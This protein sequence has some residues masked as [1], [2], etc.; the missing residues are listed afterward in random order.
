MSLE[1]KALR[2]EVP[3]LS[4]RLG[5]GDTLRLVLEYYLNESNLQRNIFGVRSAF[6]KRSKSATDGAKRVRCNHDEDAKN[7]ASFPAP[8]APTTHVEKLRQAANASGKAAKQ[9]QSQRPADKPEIKSVGAAATETRE[10][11]PD[12]SALVPVRSPGTGV[13]GP[14]RTNEGEDDHDGRYAVEGK[15]GISGE[16]SVVLGSGSQSQRQSHDVQRE[17]LASS[18]RRRVRPADVATSLLLE[19]AEK[20]ADHDIGPILKF[21]AESRAGAVLLAGATIS[22]EPEPVA[23]DGSN[24]ASKIAISGGDGT[25]SSSVL[26]LAST[27]TSSNAPPGEVETTRSKEESRSSC[28]LKP[29]PKVEGGAAAGASL[30]LDKETAA[31]STVSKH[32]G[33]KAGD[34]NEELH[35]RRSTRK[36]ARRCR[37]HNGKRR[38][39]LFDVGSEN[40]DEAGAS[41]GAPDLLN[42]AF[43]FSIYSQHKVGQLQLT[44]AAGTTREG[45][46]RATTIQ[47]EPPVAA[48]YRTSTN[49]G[50]RRTTNNRRGAVTT[51]GLNMAKISSLGG[52]EVGDVESRSRNEPQRPLS[53]RVVVAE[54]I[55][56]T[57][58]GL[59]LIAVLQLEPV[60]RLGVYLPQQVA[61]ALRRSESLFVHQG[62]LFRFHPVEPEPARGAKTSTTTTTSSTG[63]RTLYV[64]NA[65]V[66]LS[67][68]ALLV[69]FAYLVRQ[70][71]Q[72]TEGKDFSR[73]SLGGE[74]DG[75]CVDNDDVDLVL[76]AET[77]ARRAQQANSTR[78][79][80][81]PEVHL[82]QQIVD[83]DHRRNNCSTGPTRGSSRDHLPKKFFARKMQGE[84][85]RISGDSYPAARDLPQHIRMSP[86]PRTNRPAAHV[87]LEF[88]SLET[89]LLA[90]A[91]LHNRWPASWPERRDGKVLRVLHQ[92]ELNE[93]RKEYK[94][95]GAINHATSS[96]SSRSR[97]TTTTG[98]SGLRGPTSQMPDSAASEIVLVRLTLRC[99]PTHGDE[100]EDQALTPFAVRQY[101]EHAVPVQHVHMQGVGKKVKQRTELL[102]PSKSKTSIIS[103]TSRPLFSMAS[104][105]PAADIHF[106]QDAVVR[107]SSA[108]DVSLLVRDIERS[109]RFLGSAVPQVG[110]FTAM[111][112]LNYFN[113]V[114]VKLSETRK[115]QARMVLP[116][117]LKRAGAKGGAPS[118]FSSSLGLQLSSPASGTLYQQP[119]LMSK[120]GTG[121]EA[122]PPEEKKLEQEVDVLVSSRA[123]GEADGD[124]DF[125]AEVVQKK[126]R[127]G[128]LRRKH[129]QDRLR[130]PLFCG[131]ANP[132]RIV[133]GGPVRAV[134]H[135][136][137]VAPAQAGVGAFRWQRDPRSAGFTDIGPPPKCHD[138]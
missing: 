41:E 133:R 75:S 70:E 53:S 107:L 137:L 122:P 123:E 82:A 60:R 86:H 80:E 26:K 43:G 2:V 87:F 67:L 88:E 30:H 46:D 91:A 51:S 52:E 120:T 116:N 136:A 112:Q 15:A 113:D 81:T 64:E 48:N 100:D 36:R 6:E 124:E 44:G 92:E 19:N 57:Q 20:D 98:G 38:R 18:K 74:E 118:G 40:G 33:G 8:P 45:K 97:G 17:S 85:G 50:A 22:P 62:K 110:R 10:T 55:M 14:R 27:L 32:A 101:C 24:S 4:P 115:T 134:M 58:D 54:A 94:R 131:G 7:A 23:E 89:A 138:F 119:L 5:W 42:P 117:L 102:D 135:T 78:T 106:Y 59:D 39:K 37:N 77:A 129:K 16:E 73:G 71:R 109:Q 31:T 29:G 93:Q 108:A 125:F 69:G 126:E 128:G 25:S 127:D 49:A 83:D 104:T 72:R 1:R 11:D 103:S 90:R 96:T 47:P 84:S 34:H 9:S 56:E 130:V 79:S 111:E 35:I 65:P 3:D 12:A 76:A 61:Q 21:R 13:G 95:L 66:F 114:R 132:Q 99:S 105:R 63:K 121:G 68:S 28:S